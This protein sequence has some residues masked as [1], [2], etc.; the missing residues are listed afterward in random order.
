MSFLGGK[1]EAVLVCVD[2]P[3]AADKIVQLVK[4]EFP[5]VKLFVR[6]FDRGHSL[7]LIAAGV[8][9]HIRETFESA[10]V[11]GREAA[12]LDRR[13][14]DAVLIHGDGGELQWLRAAF[15]ASGPFSF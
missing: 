7:R 1:A 13:R 11:L 10:M 9:Y 12:A 5:G 14:F 15:D 6:A 3:E 8:D 4:S 2:K